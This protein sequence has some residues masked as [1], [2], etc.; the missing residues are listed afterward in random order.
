LAALPADPVLLV[1][2]NCEHVLDAAASVVAALLA[3]PSLSVL[4]TSREPLAIP[5]EIRWTVS[6]L[7][8]PLAEKQATAAR[9]IEVDSV[10]LASGP[11]G[12]P[13]DMTAS[14]RALSGAAWASWS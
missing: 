11:R 14:H 1:V 10:K 2:D 8:L 13:H 9:L 7:A 5:G 12:R 3:H 6:A 4:A